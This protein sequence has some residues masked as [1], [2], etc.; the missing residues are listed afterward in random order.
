MLVAV[1]LSMGW[2]TL[3]IGPIFPSP[4]ESANA[5]FA[6]T[7][8][9]TG[10]LIASEPL[11][12]FVGG[13]IHPRSMVAP[14]TSILPASFLGFPILT[15]AMRYVF[16]T[17]GEFVFTP[18]LAISA[19]IA[20]WWVVKRYVKDELFADLASLF[21][22]THPAFW[23]YGARVMMPNVAFV[24][25][26]ILGVVCFVKACDKKSMVFGLCA[27]L[28]VGLGLSTRLVEAPILCVVAGIVLI[29]HYRSV[30]WRVLFGA[31]FGGLGILVAYLAMNADMYGS[32]MTTGYTIP[33]IALTPQEVSSTSIF[34]TIGHMVI[35]FGIHPK[36]MLVN[37]FWY[38][39]WLFPLS[40]TLAVVGT[41]IAWR[42]KTHQ[43]AWRTFVL[44]V[45]V[46][47]VWLIAVYGSWTIADNPDPKAITIGNSHV[48]YWLPL[49][50]ASSVLVALLCVQW[51]REMLPVHRG[52]R[53]SPWSIGVMVGVLL[54]QNWT[55]V[56][57]G[58]DGLIAARAAAVVSEGKRDAVLEYTESDAV[59][60]VDRADKYFFPARRV[61]VPLRDDSTYAAM[62]TLVQHVP[63]YYF[64]ITFP[65]IDLA[66]L[67]EEK[68]LLMGLSITPI[69]TIDN[70]TLY[71]ISRIAL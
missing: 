5:F 70:E 51:L 53:R 42:M 17:F 11:N 52:L 28:I 47:S 9:E 4:D 40:S 15:G 62:P 18:M 34:T 32:V 26:L 54:L 63:L 27:G 36:A 58:D 46:A 2:L 7:F 14:G 6:Q 23:Y 25:L 12:E 68:L 33:A 29:R 31:I 65:E 10:V 22:L 8:A 48:R 16:G 44:C 37:A 1:F 49:F 38:G 13:I 59:I 71:Q 43:K 35:P 61:I 66:Y 39:W 3:G 57:R 30:S 55:A 45:V 20:L 41:G 56:F 19:V 24:S 67:N 21:L 60:I 64:G 50:A 69:V